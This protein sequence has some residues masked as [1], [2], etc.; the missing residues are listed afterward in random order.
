MTT[1]LIVILLAFACAAFGQKPTKAP[2]CVAPDYKKLQICYDPDIVPIYDNKTAQFTVAFKTC[3][4]NGDTTN[5]MTHFL[6]NK[7]FDKKN[8]NALNLND[9]KIQDQLSGQACIF[10]CLINQ[11]GQI[12]NSDGS[13]NTEVLS[14]VFFTNP[15]QRTFWGMR[16]I[17]NFQLCLDGL[18]ALNIPKFT[19]KQFKKSCDPKWFLM[20]QCIIYK[21]WAEVLDKLYVFNYPINAIFEKW[22]NSNICNSTSL[23]MQTCRTGTIFETFQ[24][25]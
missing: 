12:V 20:T 6:L 15:N 5:Y 23:T 25:S 7:M 4:G 22:T 16:F 3:K 10:E 8:S 9:K 14:A 11:N 13:V 18:A 1:S 21:A 24:L 2:D 19:S 17:T